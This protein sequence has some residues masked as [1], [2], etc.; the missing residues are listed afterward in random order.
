VEFAVRN[1]VTNPGLLSGHAAGKNRSRFHAANWRYMDFFY[2][3]HVSKIE[4]ETI[5][6][7]RGECETSVYHSWSLRRTKLNTRKS[8]RARPEPAQ[9]ARGTSPD[10]TFDY[11]RIEVSDGK[12]T[13]N[14]DV[15]WMMFAG[16]KLKKNEVFMPAE[17]VPPI[18]PTSRADR[19]YALIATLDQLT[20]KPL[21]LGLTQ[22]QRTTI[23]AELEGLDGPLSE[24]AAG[25]KLVVILNILEGEKKTL[26]AA[27]F[28]D[29]DI[30][31]MPILPEPIS[32]NRRRDENA[33]HLKSLRERL[34]AK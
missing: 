4:A 20:G 19:L 7:D 3:R 9:C 32:N 24:T 15:A 14:N 16:Y 25:K 34:A 33:L 5:D 27:G 23:A 22:E 21:T 31:T 8:S 12:R 1:K 28:R 11:T 6:S 17:F 2:W 29:P 13:E 18:L 26:E 30:R 10:L